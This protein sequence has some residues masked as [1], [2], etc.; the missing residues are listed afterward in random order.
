MERL[1][2][3]KL[4]R[5]RFLACSPPQDILMASLTRVAVSTLFIVEVNAAHIV[6]NQ[7]HNLFG[8]IVD[9]GIKQRFGVSP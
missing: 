8:G 6:V 9:A 1:D 7:V 5:Q 2:F 4:F 3:C